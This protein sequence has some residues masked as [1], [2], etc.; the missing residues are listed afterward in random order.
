MVA[1]ERI[2][3]EVTDNMATIIRKNLEKSQDSPRLCLGWA[4]LDK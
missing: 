2:P 1:I 4:L 3:R